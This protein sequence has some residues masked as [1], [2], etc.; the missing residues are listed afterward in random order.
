AILAQQPD[1]AVALNALG[2]ILTIRTERFEEAQRYIEQALALDP[3]N[4]AILDS[5]GWV[6]FR[7]GDT[8][9]AL[10]YLAQA[11][12]A[13]PDPEVAAHYGEALWVSGNEEQARIIWEQGLEQAPEH[14]ILRETIER[15]TGNGNS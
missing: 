15:L 6:R 8:E 13:Q 9:S 5:M 12:A 1:N 14:D 11:W 2:Y 4:P 10:T 3:G 7:Q